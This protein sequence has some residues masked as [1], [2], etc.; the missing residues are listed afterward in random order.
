MSSPTAQSVWTAGPCDVRNVG[1]AGIRMGR[2]SRHP[3][4]ARMWPPLPRITTSLCRSPGLMAL[5]SLRQKNAHL[6]LAPQ[7]RPTRPRLNNPRPLPRLLSLRHRHP[8]RQTPRA[9][10]RGRA[11]RPKRKRPPGQVPALLRLRYQKT[12]IA[13]QHRQLT[14]ALPKIRS[15]RRSKMIHLR[16]Q[17]LLKPT[18]TANRK[19]SITMKDRSSITSRPSVRAETRSRSGR[20]QA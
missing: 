20:Q 8:P 10:M 2:R 7:R 19:P 14:R 15:T 4:R 3:L 11:S 5:M 6:Q 1:T 13:V 17:P 12:R 9:P 18:P 16:R